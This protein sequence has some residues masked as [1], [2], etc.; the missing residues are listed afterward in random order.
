MAF[1]LWHVM[2]CNGNSIVPIWAGLVH[3]LQALLMLSSHVWPPT[4]LM[5][6]ITGDIA[7][8]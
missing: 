7:T 3:R 2:T 4:G 6:R 1:L 5:K 8:S